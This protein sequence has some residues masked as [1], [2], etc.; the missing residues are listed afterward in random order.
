MWEQYGQALVL[1]VALLH[2]VAIVDVWMSQLNSRV[3]LLWT[4][5]LLFLIGVGLVAWGITRGSAHRPPEEI[6]ELEE[7]AEPNEL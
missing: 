4:V 2:F 5:T 1:G 3:K 7:T 6:V